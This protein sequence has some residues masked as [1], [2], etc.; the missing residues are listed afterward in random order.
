MKALLKI[1]LSLLSLGLALNAFAQPYTEDKTAITVSAAKPEF[2]LQLKSNPTTGYSWFLKAFNATY[3]EA[4]EHHYKAPTD[5][6]LV[7]APGY[8]LWTFKAKPA[9]FK[10]PVQTSLHFVYVR[11]W[12]KN[13]DTQGV[14]FTVSTH[15]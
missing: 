10:V 4:V 2:V 13:K 5:K 15:K 14:V 11:P 9:A 1:S 3:I 7:G 8:E 12:E 6:T